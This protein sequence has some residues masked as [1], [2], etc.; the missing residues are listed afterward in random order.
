[1]SDRLTEHDVARLLSDPSVESRAGLTPKLARQLDM[2]GLSDRARAM[3][4]DIIRKL[5]AD[6][7]DLIRATLA[8][9]LKMSPRVPHDVAR[10]LASDIDSVSMPILEFSSVLTQDDLVELIAQSSEEGHVAV[11]RR[12]DLND[13]VADALLDRAT[14]RVAETIADNRAAALGDSVLNRI[15]DD[16]GASPAVQRSLKGRPGLS[17]TV[18]ER[19]V[20]SMSDHLRKVLTDRQALPEG[21]ATDL[22]LNARERATLSL[23]SSEADRELGDLVAQLKRAGRLSPSLLFR[24][25]CVGD[26]GFFEAGMASLADIPVHNAR[27]LIY[28]QG[29][30]AFRRLYDKAALPERLFP[31]FRM[32][33]DLVNNTDMRSAD[34]DPQSY[35]R[36]MM[37]RILT[38][39]TDLHPEEADYLLDRLLDIAPRMETKHGAS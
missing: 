15:A 34:F 14:D 20:A 4:E 8:E 19:L 30:L 36:M 9:S 27:M 12:T 28:D 33:V 10:Q 37:E 2:D 23:A 13:A 38:Q 1:M 29:N 39:A 21:V 35:S 16:H 18:A 11:A 26:T 24:A 31:A 5:S 32:A 25:V 7:S 22:V 17:A 6:A 3:A